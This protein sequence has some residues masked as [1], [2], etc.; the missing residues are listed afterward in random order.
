MSRVNIACFFFFFTLVGS[1]AYFDKKIRDSNDKIVSLSNDILSLTKNI[2]DLKV[3]LAS[4]ETIQQP[5]L[6]HDVASYN[7]EL[8]LF[9]VKYGLYTMSA[10]LALLLIYYLASWYTPFFTLKYWNAYLFGTSLKS[11]DFLPSMMDRF[12]QLDTIECVDVCG[13]LIK[14]VFCPDRTFDIFIKRTCDLEYIQID[15]LGF[16]YSTFTEVAQVAASPE[17]AAALQDFI[18]NIQM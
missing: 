14:I 11:V 12:K 13:T 8:T 9:L 17:V 10:I 18:N 1:A 4:R 16:M 6:S 3:E 2:S 15:N 5:L 7:P